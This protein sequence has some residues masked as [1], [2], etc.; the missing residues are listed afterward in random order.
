VEID[1]SGQE[2]FDGT[3][4]NNH[5][6][7]EVSLRPEV[8]PANYRQTTMEMPVALKRLVT[9]PSPEVNP[10]SSSRQTTMEMPV[11]LKRL[12]TPPSPYG[13]AQM[14]ERPSVTFRNQELHSHLDVQ[15]NSNSASLFPRTHSTAT[16]TTDATPDTYGNVIP[17]PLSIRLIDRLSSRGDRPAVAPFKGGRLSSNGGIFHDPL[18]EETKMPPKQASPDAHVGPYSKQR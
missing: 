9:P 7:F 11:A 13:P 5:P 3:W 17:R 1:S 6:A 10:A 14:L 18:H 8:N 12:V 2:V 16:A 4:E 15:S